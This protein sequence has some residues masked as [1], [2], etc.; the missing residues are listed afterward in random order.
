MPCSLCKKTGHNIRTCI[1]KKEQDKAKAA[2]EAKAVAE[3][4]AATEAN[5]TNEVKEFD[6]NEETPPDEWFYGKLSS[7]VK[8]IDNLTDIMINGITKYKK[9]LNTSEI[10]EDCSFEDLGSTIDLWFEHDSQRNNYFNDIVKED[11]FNKLCDN[12][13]SK[14]FTSDI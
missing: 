5:F 14:A 2:T 9:Y 1:I 13:I 4:K 10:E 8:D 12:I 6:D 11:E 7:P 3:A